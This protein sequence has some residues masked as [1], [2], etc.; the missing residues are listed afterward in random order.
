LLIGNGAPVEPLKAVGQLLSAGHIRNEHEAVVLFVILQSFGLQLSFEPFMT[1]HADLNIERHPTLDADMQQTVDRIEKIEIQT[2]AF[3]AGVFE[4]RTALAV[5]DAKA[6]AGFRRREDTNKPLSDGVAFDDLFNIRLFAQPAVEVDVGTVLL[7]G[8]LFG[9][10]LDLIGVAADKRFELLDQ[11]MV[12]AKKRLEGV[13]PV[14]G[15]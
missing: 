2:E 14:I 7:F 15:R 6:L 5:E 11:A 9:R 4:N 12:A 13:G 8:H 1:V 3:A 10:L